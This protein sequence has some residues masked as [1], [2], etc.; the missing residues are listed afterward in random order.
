MYRYLRFLCGS[1]RLTQANELCTQSKNCVFLS[2]SI[3]FN[4]GIYDSIEMQMLDYLNCCMLAFV[5]ENAASLYTCSSKQ[6]EEKADFVPQLSFERK[7]FKGI[8]E[9]IP[10]DIW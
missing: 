7:D 9:S 2:P 3:H 8:F 6:K 10:V 4:V 1:A 5:E